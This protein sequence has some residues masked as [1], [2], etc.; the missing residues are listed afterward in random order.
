M[1]LQ[2]ANHDGLVTVRHCL[3]AVSKYMQTGS[4][5]LSAHLSSIQAVFLMW[6]SPCEMSYPFATDTAAFSGH[7]EPVSPTYFIRQLL[8]AEKPTA[9]T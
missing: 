7:C 9:Y 2:L 1:A 3:Q 4:Q 5:A 8:P 6:V